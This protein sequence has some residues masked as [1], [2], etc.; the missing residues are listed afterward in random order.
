MYC[1]MGSSLYLCNSY[2]SCCK[3]KFHVHNLHS[4]YELL[5]AQPENNQSK[6][7]NVFIQLIRNRLDIKQYHV[8]NLNAVLV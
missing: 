6:E 2:I 8:F 1:H 7:S 5:L 4:F 3:V